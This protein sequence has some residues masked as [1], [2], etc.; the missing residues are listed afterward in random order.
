M[1]LI[2]IRK[3]SQKRERRSTIDFNCKLIKENIAYKYKPLL[4]FSQEEKEEEEEDEQN[5]TVIYESELIAPTRTKVIIKFPNF[6]LADDQS[7]NYYQLFRAILCRDT[8]K[9]SVTGKSK[10]TL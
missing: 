7:T 2:D 6:N 4:F 1:N 8:G 9:R 5:K 3:I 10:R